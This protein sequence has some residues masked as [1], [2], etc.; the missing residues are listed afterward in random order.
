MQKL[1][2]PKISMKAVQK[3]NFKNLIVVSVSLIA[4]TSH[5]RQDLAEQLV[6]EWRNVY[7][8]IV[9][10]KKGKTVDVLTADSTNWEAKLKIHPVHTHFE[11]NGTY[12]SEYFNLKDSLVRKTEGIWFIKGS[13]ITINQLKPSKAV[14][15]YEL[16]I[17]NNYATFS[18]YIDFNEDGKE[19]DYYF[20]IQKKYN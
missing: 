16:S 18:G 14:Y 12:Y 8:N 5:V 15:K 19:D 10:N 3:F 7:L 1:N 20:G 9:V 6:G 13:K 4:F 11:S 17:N 2:Q